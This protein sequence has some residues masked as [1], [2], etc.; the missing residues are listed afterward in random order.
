MVYY[1]STV[2]ISNSLSQGD[3]AARPRHS[4]ARKY[5]ENDGFCVN[6]C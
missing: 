2:N 1:H 5:V 6:I 3:S 4:K